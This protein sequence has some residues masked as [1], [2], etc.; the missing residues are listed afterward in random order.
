MDFRQGTI[1]RG[2][3]YINDDPGSFFRTTML[4]CVL[5][6]VDLVL[7]CCTAIVQN[8]VGA[9]FFGSMLFFMSDSLVGHLTEL[10]DNVRTLLR[11][12]GVRHTMVPS[13]CR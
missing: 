3:L 8:R 4:L 7:K 11:F 9:F 1:V 6:I 2:A 5:Q 12:E 13:A 10:F